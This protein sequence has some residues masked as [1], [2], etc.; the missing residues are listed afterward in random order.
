MSN[1]KCNVKD[2]LIIMGNGGK[3]EYKYG[4]IIQDSV[5]VNDF[6]APNGKLFRDALIESGKIKEIVEKTEKKESVREEKKK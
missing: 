2:G 4:D 1:C 3:K 6:P 5:F